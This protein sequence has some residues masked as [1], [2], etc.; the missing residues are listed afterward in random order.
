MIDTLPISIP[1]LSCAGK[2]I[3]LVNQ[4]KYLGII[5]DKNLTFQ[6][7]FQSVCKKVS[8]SIGCLLHIK[9]YL[10]NHAFKI[11]INSFVLTVIDYGFPIWGHLSQFHLKLLQTKINHLLGAFYYPRIFNKYKK[12]L[13][14]ARPHNIDYRDL[15]ERCNIFSITERLEY[16]YLIFAYKS[17]RNCN[18][19]EI[20][21]EFKFLSSSRTNKL[22]LPR[23]RTTLFRKSIF[24]QAAKN[25]NCLPLEAKDND[26]SYGQ[27]IKLISQWILD[28]RLK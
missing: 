5:F 7:H 24:F 14:Y 25:W 15:W 6:P 19:R 28:K 21:D 1:E 8:S 11:L 4:Y 13:H 20:A 16:F 18:I 10:T 9:R 12:T 2:T 22:L 26:V 23:H 27:Y 17:V 3:E